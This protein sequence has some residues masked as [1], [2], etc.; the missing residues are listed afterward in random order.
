MANYYAT[1]RSNYF[2]VKNTQ[3]FEEWCSKRHLDC[4]AKPYADIGDR[5]AI[6]P[7]SGMEAGWPYSELDEA[8][9]EY[10]EIDFPKELASHL[11]PRDIA[12]LIEV[13]SEKLRYLTGEAVAVHATGKSIR[14]SLDDIYDQAMREF[15]GDIMERPVPLLSPLAKA[16]PL[17]VRSWSYS[18][19]AVILVSALPHQASCFLSRVISR[20]RLVAIC[21]ETQIIPL[22]NST[23]VSARPW[24][25][26]AIIGLSSAAAA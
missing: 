6:A 4:W 23:T 22:L 18:K 15:A 1:A 24:D 3:A 21:T 10:Y 11:D 20:F 9:D 17:A 13:G 5:Y 7:S 16:S 12:I 26:R 14:I 2:R 8:A 19:E 25:T